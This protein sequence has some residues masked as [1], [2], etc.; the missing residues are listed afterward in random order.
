MG[1]RHSQLPIHGVQFHPESIATEH[2]HAMLAN[3]LR[4]CGIEARQRSH[5]LVAWPK[6][7][8]CSGACSTAAWTRPIAAVLVEMAERGETAQRIAGAVRAMRARMKRIAAPAD[9]IDVCGTGGDGQHSL[10]VSTAVA[11]VVAAC[12]VPVAKHGNRAASSKAGAA[13]TLEA[14]GLEPRPGKRDGGA[15]AADLGIAFLFAPAHHPALGRIAPIRKALGRRTIFNLLGPLANPAGVS[16]PACRRRRARAGAALPRGDGT[17]RNARGADRLGRPKGWTS[18]RSPAP[19]GSPRS[20]LP[21][22]AKPPR[23]GMPACPATASMPCAGARPRSTP[24]RC[25]GCSW[26]SRAPIATRYCSIPPARCSS[27]GK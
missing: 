3:F 23:P 24:R 8:R 25:G 21:G 5:D 16:P 1:F 26:A 20:D 14:L 22:L 2:G 10:N 9:A 15:N 19:A 7:K 4:I 27:R 13:D 6:P 12:D 17:A 18:C 11:L